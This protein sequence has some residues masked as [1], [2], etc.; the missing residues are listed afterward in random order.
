MLR[1]FK[2]YV[3][4]AHRELGRALLHSIRSSEIAPLIDAFHC[5][6]SFFDFCADLHWFLSVSFARR[7]LGIFAGLGSQILLAQKICFVLP[8]LTPIFC[9]LPLARPERLSVHL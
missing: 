9:F 6:R 5:A 3:R 7:F 1:D 8:N 4:G 2:G